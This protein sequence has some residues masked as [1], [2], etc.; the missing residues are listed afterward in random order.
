MV[1]TIDRLGVDEVKVRTPLTCET[2]HGLCAH[3]YGRD[4][5]RGSPVNRAK[6]LAS[7]PPSPSVNRARS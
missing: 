5:G 1:D 7:S 3:C 4:L 2:R 6:R